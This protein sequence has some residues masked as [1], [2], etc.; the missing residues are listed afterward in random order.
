MIY[1]FFNVGVEF[2][3]DTK[4][5]MWICKSKKYRQYNV[6]KKKEKHRSCSSVITRVDVL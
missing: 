6:Q 2:E 4:G 3:D 5:V 1:A